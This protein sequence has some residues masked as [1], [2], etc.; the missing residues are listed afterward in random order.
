[1]VKNDT[2]LGVEVV[3]EAGVLMRVMIIV[4]NDKLTD[5]EMTKECN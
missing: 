5:D 4:K 3:T 1:M 2:L